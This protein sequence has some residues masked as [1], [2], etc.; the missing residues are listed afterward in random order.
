[1]GTGREGRS[2]VLDWQEYWGKGLATRA[3]SEFLRELRIR[4][5][6]A[7]A[8]KDNIASLRV[9]EKCGFVIVGSPWGDANA[10]GGE[11]EELLL[12]LGPEPEVGRQ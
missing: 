5:I 8:A 10:R 11:V 1:M 4:P 3:L 12:E 2:D 9:L 7:A 6:Y